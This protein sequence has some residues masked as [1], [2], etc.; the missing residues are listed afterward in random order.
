MTSKNRCTINFTYDFNVH[1]Q[2][3]QRTC[4]HQTELQWFAGVSGISSAHPGW[5]SPLTDISSAPQVL[6]PPL[7]GALMC[8]Q[9]SFWSIE[10]LSILSQLLQ[11]FCCRS[12]P[13]SKGLIRPA[14]MPSYGCILS[15]H[16]RIQVYTP[17]SLRHSRWLPVTNIHFADGSGD[18]LNQYEVLPT[19][20]SQ[21]YPRLRI[22][23]PNQPHGSNLHPHLARSRPHFYSQ[24]RTQ[25]KVLPL[26]LSMS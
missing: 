2:C 19:N 8:Y 16:W 12:W 13:R 24:R 14:G 21:L 17:H 6:S 11:W 10:V 15:Y 20:Q 23:T 3:S 7:P 9:N 25:S 4:L 26:F 5:L 1:Q 22:S 18:S